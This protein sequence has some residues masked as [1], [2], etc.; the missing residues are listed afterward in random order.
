MNRPHRLAAT[1]S[2]LTNTQL[3]VAI[4]DLVAEYELR[5]QFTNGGITAIEAVY[6]FPIPLDSAFLG[7]EATLAGETLV[8]EVMPARGASRQYDDA[9][10]EGDSAVLLE[11]LEPGM[12]CVNLGNLEAGE[13]GEIV[14][15]FA[16]P[17][18]AADNMVRFSLPL[19]HRPRYGRSRLDE[20][21]EPS[22][23]FSIEH[24]LQATI[25]VCGLLASTPV[26]C[27][28][29][30]ARFAQEDGSLVLHL[31][32]AMLDRDLVLRF[33]LPQALLSHGRLVED[34]DQSIGILSFSTPAKA[35]AATPTDFCLLLDGSGSM[36]GD[37]I[38]QSR[39]ALIAVATNLGD[40]DRIQVLRFGSTTVPMFRRPLKGSLRVCEALKSLADT[41]DAD[42]GGTEIGNALDSALDALNGLESQGRSQAIILVTDGAVQPEELIVAKA[43]AAD[44]GIRIFV[45]AVGSS[46]GADVLA[47]LAESTRAVLE[48]AVPAEPIDAC[49]MRQ[50]RRARE[51]V[52]LQI[53]VD[54]GSSRAKPLPRAVAYP[55]DTITAIAFLPLEYRGAAHVAMSGHERVLSF[56]LNELQPMLA[57]RAIVGTQAYQH[58]SQADREALALRYALITAET[59]AVLV[60]TR[61]QTE[62]ADG[63]PTIRPV[64][65][66]TPAGM[67]ANYC[68][69]YGRGHMV[70]DLSP[71]SVECSKSLSKNVAA[72]AVYSQHDLE[73][74]DL[75]TGSSKEVPSIL[76]SLSPARIDE[77]K[78]QLMPL[79]VEWLFADH[80]APVTLRVLLQRLDPGLLQDALVFAGMEGVDLEGDPGILLELLAEEGVGGP[81]SDD[82][83]AWLAERIAWIRR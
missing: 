55:G 41:V 32:Q 34:G 6:S 4:T 9:I 48:R 51:S 23:D 72:C 49:V 56:T 1:N 47:P 50:A 52:P 11:R 10:A 78:Q 33:E 12:L 37:A 35:A 31:S 70:H 44:T 45:V 57:M 39:Q 43:R 76:R 25:R 62:K 13:Q 46:A 69:A 71:F 17:L 30:G 18:H 63:L 83:E 20:V 42:L 75:A 5:H 3:Q 21:A 61:M 22:N 36:A 58:A 64:K 53:E 28:T 77:I 27:A 81:L 65:H 38:S 74:S 26:H 68:A 67:V 7:M 2:P 79:L 73:L 54:W 14:L 16:A 29:H 60:K 19:V 80:Q 8:A 59:S 40:D 82:L 15:R 66:M 24:P